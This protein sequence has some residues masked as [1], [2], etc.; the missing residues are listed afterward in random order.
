MRIPVRFA[1]IFFLALVS[2][3]AQWVSLFNGKDLSGWKP[4][5]NAAWKVESGVIVGQWDPAKPGGGWLMS[6][7]EFS[8]FVLQ[9]EF[10]G[11]PKHANSGVAIRDPLHG[12]KDPAY[13]GYEIQIL[14]IPDAKM[15]TGSV[16]NVQKAKYVP[17]KDGWNSMEITARG[18]HIV[19]LL[20][21]EK[22][23]ETDDD[24]SLQGSVG[25]QSHSQG[26]VIYFRNIR[27]Q[28]LK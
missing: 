26:E 19:V 6:E 10:R 20:N 17:L 23:A 21:G 16:Y 8:D 22:V 9:V 15:P 11:E 14:D 27:I 3:E 2:L 24:R 18:T 5:G 4:A 1:V 25:F 28:K 12:A 7:R 13:S